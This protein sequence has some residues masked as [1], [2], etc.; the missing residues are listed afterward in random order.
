MA[1]P[2]CGSSV[3]VGELIVDEKTWGPYLNAN[4]EV[5]GGIT[6]RAPV[7]YE[8]RTSC[9]ITRY[10]LGAPVRFSYLVR[11]RI[12]RGGRRE[13]EDVFV[14]HIASKLYLFEGPALPRSLHLDLWRARCE[15]ECV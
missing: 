13:T 10:R 2:L 14:E 4:R 9:A 15:A 12:C 8:W 5:P 6:Q 11:W 7:S 3:D 1:P